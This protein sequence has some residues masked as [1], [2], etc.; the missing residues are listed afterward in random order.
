M[1]ETINKLFPGN[2]HSLFL[3][4]STK[5]IPEAIK[6]NVLP[7]CDVALVD[8]GHVYPV[9]R[10]DIANFASHMSEDNLILFDDYPS[11]W[12]KGFGKSWDEVL[13]GP[14][15]KIGTPIDYAKVMSQILVFYV[16]KIV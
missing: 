16:L 15:L 9:A 4:D 10:A 11:N 1:N 2:R 14:T 13:Y 3:G 8:G 12:G 7:L 5:T 6:N